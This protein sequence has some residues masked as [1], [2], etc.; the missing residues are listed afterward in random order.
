MAGRLLC[1][2]TIW[3]QTASRSM[4]YGYCRVHKRHGG[5]SA[6][7]QDRMEVGMPKEGCGKGTI[8]IRQEG[9]PKQN[10]HHKK[11]PSHVNNCK[12]L[13]TWDGPATGQLCVHIYTCGICVC[14]LGLWTRL[15]NASLYYMRLVS[16]RLSGLV[17][18][19]GCWP[20]LQGPPR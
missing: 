18:W 7:H 14:A 12:R 17:Q 5:W 1:P 10:L 20:G 2:G 11:E 16:D 15:D 19:L 8:L 3:G 4:Q 6:P 9:L 13:L